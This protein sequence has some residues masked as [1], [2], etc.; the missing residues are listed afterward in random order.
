[1][2][3]STGSHRV[4]FLARNSVKPFATFIWTINLLVH[5]LKT[6]ALTIGLCHDFSANDTIDIIEKNIIERQTNK[7]RLWAKLLYFI[8]A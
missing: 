4:V 1:M 7:K 5:H 2:S 8:D 3:Q 6:I